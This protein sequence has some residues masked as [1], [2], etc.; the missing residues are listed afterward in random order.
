MNVNTSVYKSANPLTLAI[1]YAAPS[2]VEDSPS[3]AKR[4]LR[5]Q[6]VRFLLDNGANI[7]KGSST[8]SPLAVARTI[9]DDKDLEELLLLAGANPET[10]KEEETSKNKLKKMNAALMELVYQVEASEAAEKELEEMKKKIIGND[11]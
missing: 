5:L 8:Q 2:R 11:N 1:L 6:M 10:T 4:F 9:D 7:N 3:E